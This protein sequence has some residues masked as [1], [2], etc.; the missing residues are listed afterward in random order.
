MYNEKLNCKYENWCT[1][2]NLVKICKLNGKYVN[3]CTMRNWM[4]ILRN[5]INFVP[6]FTFHKLNVKGALVNA[7]P[8]LI[9]LKIRKKYDN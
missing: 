3:W 4:V 1:M 2:R 6:C 8:S 7:P 9:K 5:K